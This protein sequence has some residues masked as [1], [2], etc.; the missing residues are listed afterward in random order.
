MAHTVLAWVQS[1]PKTWQSSPVFEK[2]AE[3]D[4]LRDELG[5]MN[6]EIIDEVGHTLWMIK[7]DQ[8]ASIGK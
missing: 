3:S 1:Y 4:T 8:V 5:D 6:V 2:Y 7:N